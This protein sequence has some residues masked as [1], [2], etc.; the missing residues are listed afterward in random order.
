MNKFLLITCS[1]LVA[2]STGRVN[3]SAQSDTHSLVKSKVDSFFIAMSTGDSVWME[4]NLL[5][6]IQLTSIESGKDKNE[7]LSRSNFINV[8]ASFK[9]KDIKIQE[10]LFN[11][12]IRIDANLA[13]VESDYKLFVNDYFVHCGLDVFCLNY[14]N[15]GWKI[16]SV[17][18]TRKMQDCY[19]DPI[20]DINFL[21]DSWHNAA[22]TAN[23][24]SFFGFMAKDAIY[25]GTDKTERWTRDE[26]KEW[27]K[28][29]FASESAWEFKPIERKVYLSEDGQFAWFNE[30]LNTW[31]GV[32]RGSGTLTKEID[33]WKLKQYQL[34]VTIDNDKINGFV[35]LVGAPGRKK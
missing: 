7:I 3:L 19:S 23:G 20:K 27:S 22:A 14:T 25:I 30:T 11:Y 10:K 6:D 12:N 33:G 9:G 4:N 35:E 13:I 18:D 34:A 21:M 31:M 24:E 15:T 8:V 32:C 28:K 16:L 2:F 29:Y 5:P 26:L 1:F 17:Y